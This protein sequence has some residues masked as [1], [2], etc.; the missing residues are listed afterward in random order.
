MIS[1]ADIFRAK[2]RGCGEGLPDGR[3]DREAYSP[4]WMHLLKSSGMGMRSWSWREPELRVCTR[5]VDDVAVS[6]GTEKTQK[7][8]GRKPLTSNR[9]DLHNFRRNQLTMAA[10]IYYQEDCNLAASGR[11]DNRN[12][13]LRQPGTCTWH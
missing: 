6:S 9:N 5:G 10:R 11:T 12:Y 8:R 7:A 13:R 1:V 3:A 4:S 2:D